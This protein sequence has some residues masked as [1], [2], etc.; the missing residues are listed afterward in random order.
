VAPTGPRTPDSATLT[1]PR[2]V[3]E[4]PAPTGVSSTFRAGVAPGA[5]SS[6][7]ALGNV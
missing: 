6:T 3:K 5:L 7:Q 4:I 2:Q 1:T